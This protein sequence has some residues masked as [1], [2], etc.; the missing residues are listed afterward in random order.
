[1]K[2]LPYWFL[3]TATLFGVAGMAYGI[4]MGISEDH[5]LAPAHGHN[6]LI[7]WV[8]MAL[9]GLYYRVVPAAAKT[10]LALIHFWVSFVGALM[11]PFALALVLL[12]QS[13]V[14]ISVA[15]LLVILG[16]L[17]FSYTVWVN[18]AGLTVD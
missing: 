2:A 1:M 10:R 3:G 13:V 8:T 15:M 6:N 14:P 12:G 7:G 5:T 11:F 9:Y 17:I 4:Y 18:R 16:M